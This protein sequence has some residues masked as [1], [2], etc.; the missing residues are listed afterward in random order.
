MSFQ[1]LYL[2]F[3]YSEEHFFGYLQICHFIRKLSIPSLNTPKLSAPESFLTNCK[4]STHF[5]SSFYYLLHDICPT[6]LSNV[7]C[8]WERDLDNE[9][10]EDDWQEALSCI[11]T[12]FLAID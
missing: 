6:N 7:Q 10:I 11:K 2:Q 1:Q 3:C 8:K 5:I 12:C 9:Y 4:N